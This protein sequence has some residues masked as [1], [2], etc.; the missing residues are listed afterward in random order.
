LYA[1]NVF[2]AVGSFDL[3]PADAC[4]TTTGVELVRGACAIDAP[5][6]GLRVEGYTPPAEIIEQV[7]RISQA[8]GLDVGGIEYLVDDRDGKHYFYDVNALSN[9]V[10][11]AK[12]VIGFDPFER[13]ADY[14]ELRAGL[15][16][17]EVA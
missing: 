8:A 16:R 13:L 4:Q 12:N 2:P 5:K 14:L 11:D 6:N 7:E 17:A 9:F 1:I 3:C 10:A 15:V